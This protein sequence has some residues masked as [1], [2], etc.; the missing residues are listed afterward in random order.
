MVQLFFTA[1]S[2]LLNQFLGG[3]DGL[4]I[5]LVTFTTINYIAGIMCTI[6]DW[7]LSH[8]TDL[9]AICQKVM[10][11]IMVGMANILDTR[12]IGSE[13]ILRTAAIFFYLSHEGRSMLRNAD[14]LGLPV[15]KR[16]K[17]ILTQFYSRAEDD[18]NNIDEE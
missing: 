16:I 1:I 4:L 17:V 8:G 3:Y 9:W 6:Y 2:G 15:P 7:N 10:I 14:H 12:V 13:H 11:F 18:K 5:A